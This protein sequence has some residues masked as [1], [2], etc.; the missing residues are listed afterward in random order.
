MS[1]RKEIIARICRNS[2]KIIY[3]GTKINAV[4]FMMRRNYKIKCENYGCQYT[5]VFVV[6]F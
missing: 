6:V 5:N 1:Q 2:R 3:F 4:I